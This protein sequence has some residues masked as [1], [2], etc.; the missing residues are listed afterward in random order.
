M[1]PSDRKLI[2]VLDL[3]H[4]LAGP[5]CSMLLADLGYEIIKI[6][7]PQKGDLTRGIGP[8]FLHGMSTYF[9]SINRNK[10]SITLDLKTDKDRYM[11]YE[12]VKKSDI[13]LDN[14]RPGV[15]ARLRC[16]YKELSEIN[17]RII[18][19]SITGYGSTGPYCEQDLPSNDLVIQAM[20]GGMSLT[21]YPDQPP[22][23]MGI[24]IGDLAGG[25]FAAFAITSALYRREQTGK[26]EFIDISMMDCQ[27][28]LLNYIAQSY[29]VSEVIPGPV[30][31]GHQWYVPYQVFKTKDSYIVIAIFNDKLFRKLC[32]ALGIPELVDDP[33]FVTE[34]NRKENKEALIGILESIVE[35]KETSDLVDLLW[36]YGVTAG[37]V[38]NVA[39]ALNDP[40][41]LSRGM[42]VEMEF[43]DGS[44]V[45]T[46]G[47]PIKSTGFSSPPVS[48]PP[49]LG[50]NTLDV[51]RELLGEDLAID[52]RSG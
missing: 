16:S 15:L 40:Q 47:S 44:S 6:E 29:L 32:L 5:Y 23:R 8:Y 36:K 18:C 14:F 1:P 10:K 33:R 25:L 21:G 20:A 9:M 19:C 52:K 28:S 39:Q 12:L 51:L 17:P 27:I 38:N 24:A 31:S 49:C 3:S 22:V 50:E 11:F 41:V 46:L 48:K 30:G 34:A 4:V 42:V 7:D 26:G 13:V 43:P 35:S 45:K 37:Q 2:R